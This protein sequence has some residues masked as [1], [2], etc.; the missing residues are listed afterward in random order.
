[1]ALR[2]LRRDVG[3]PVHLDRPARR[4]AVRHRAVLDPASRPGAPVR[5]TR[6]GRQGRAR[7]LAGGGGGGAARIVGRGAEGERRLMRVA[8]LGPEGTNTHEALLAAG[9]GAAPY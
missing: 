9:G 7:A 3:T 6:P 2:L 4:A 1:R 5:Q 8:Y